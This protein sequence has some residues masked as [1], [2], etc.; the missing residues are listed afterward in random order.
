M[1][2]GFYLALLLVLVLL[3]VP[4]GLVR[5]ARE[6]RERRAGGR[7]GS[8]A[9]VVGSFGA[10]LVWGVGLAACSTAC[11]STGTATTPATCSTSSTPTRSWRDS[12]SCS[13][14]PSTARPSSRCGRR[15]TLR[16]SGA[17]AARRLAIRSRRRRRALPRLDGRGRDRPQR[18]GRL[19]AVLPAALGIAAA[20]ARRRCFG[21][22]SGPGR[23]HD[24][25]RDR[26]SLVATLFT[27]L[28]PRV[29]VSEPGLRQQP[30]GRGRLVVALRAHRDDRGRA[31]RRAARPA[32]PGL[33]VPR[34]LAAARRGGAG[35]PGSERPG[36]LAATC[37]PSTRACFAAPARRG[38]CSASTR[39]SVSRRRSRPAAGDAARR[40]VARA[41]D[42]ASLADVAPTSCCS[43]SS[44]QC[45][46]C[47]P[48][49][50]GRRAAGGASSVLSELRL[51]LVERRL[52]TQ[53][54]AL[55]GVEAGEI[56]AAAVHGVDGARGLLRR[57]LPQVVL[58]CVVPVV[59]LVW[60]ARIDLESALVML[61]TLPLVPVFMW[62]IGRYTEQRTRRAL[63]GAPAPL[64]PL[65]RRRARAADAAGVQPRPRPGA[66][67]SPR[68]ASATG[69]RRWGR[70]A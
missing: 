7:R 11:R 63:A 62:L 1:F 39:R 8:W 18:Q 40:I 69:A 21:S 34:L 19:P 57:Y 27:S 24:R 15:A 5:V 65:P 61:L 51:A 55:D 4:R 13:S 59:V 45:A 25:A 16:A 58:A 30:D 23:S 14:S 22:A 42:G 49:V 9:N 47:S 2:S 20:R 46:A 43:R 32:L 38:S 28:Y 10:P 52:R 50:R 53:P 41:F 17:H 67:R 6:E 31:D 29:M 44:S 56:A 33:D 36:R 54:A 60:V 26:R 37:A 48:G 64:D 70:C 3:I 12:R 35:S 68:S 66:R